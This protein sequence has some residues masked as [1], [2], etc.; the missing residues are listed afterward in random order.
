[1]KE[2]DIDKALV[3]WCNREGWLSRKL[4]PYRFYGTSGDPDRQL[5]IPTSWGIPMY[6]EMELKTEDGTLSKKQ[7]RRIEILKHVGVNVKV[8]YGL[9]ETMDHLEMLKAKRE[10]L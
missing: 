7:E 10:A 3:E 4:T 6:E 9:E 5:I 2:K 8:L 1:M